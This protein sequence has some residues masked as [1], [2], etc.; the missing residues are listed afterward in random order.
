MMKNFKFIFKC[1]L[2]ILPVILIML[3]TALFPF[4]YMDSEYPAWEYT[5]DVTKDAAAFLDGE[6]KVYA[7]LILGDSRAMADLIPS[8]MNEK[9]LNLAVGGAT[10]IEMY[11]TLDTYIKNNGTPAEVIIMFAPFHYSVIDNFTT[12]TA[13]FNYLT[14]SDL[15][16]LYSYA[17]ACNSETLLKKG[18]KNDLLSYRLRFPDKYIPALINSGFIG[19]YNGNINTYNEIRKNFGYSEFGKEDGCSDLNYETNYEEMHK[20]GDALLLDIYMHRLLNLCNDNKIKT[21]LLIPPM[22]ESSFN[23]LKPSYADEYHMYMD[24]LSKRHPDVKIETEIPCYPDRLFGDSSHLNKKGAEIF[25][26]EIMEKY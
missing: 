10:S 25:T 9:T 16:D 4:C 22:N 8:K 20:T 7:T 17:K 24:A 23:A 14:I 26:R 21:Y 15:N 11:Y 3:F 5:K 1:I 13:Y 19:R 2:F 6:N 12:R 18:Y